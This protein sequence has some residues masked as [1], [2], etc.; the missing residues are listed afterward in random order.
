MIL[1][2][3]LLLFVLAIGSYGSSAH[4][5]ISLT[6]TSD[7]FFG[8][9]EYDAAHDGR[10]RLGTNGALTSTG[11]GFVVSGVGIP[12]QVEISATPADVVEVKCDRNGIMTLPTGERITFNN[13]EG[14]IDS[15]VAYGSATRCDRVGGRRA[16]IAVVD[17][18]VNSSPTVL[19]GGQA[20]IRSLASGVYD[21]S[22]GGGR[23]VT[24]RVIFQ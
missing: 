9:V 5:Q 2:L 7:M 6:K 19:L 18:A 15:G 10:V 14:V 4:A 1:R 23:P 17:I 8:V 3:R 22:N 24:V 21:S 13:V 16:P 20:R 11:T 12:G